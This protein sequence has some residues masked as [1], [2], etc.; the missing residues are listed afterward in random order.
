MSDLL[1]RILSAPQEPFA[2]IYRPERDRET[3]EAFRLV[4]GTA[5]TIADAVSGPRDRLIVL[6]YAQVK[7]RKFEAVDEG[8]P[9]HTMAIEDRE[10]VFLDRLLGRLPRGDVHASGTHF[11]LEDEAFAERVRNVIEDEIGQGAGSNFVL[12]RKLRTQITDFEPLHCLA[13]FR[14][15]LLK[16]T[17]AYWAFV[18]NTGEQVFL[19]VSPE[20]HASLRDGEVTMNPISGTY[21]YPPGGPTLPSVLDFLSDGK[22]IAEL[23]MVVDEELKVMSRLCEDG[24]TAI[25]PRLKALSRVAHTE[26]LLKGRTKAGVAEVLRETLLAPT[27]TGSPVQSAC[28]VLARREP[29]GRRYYSG[30]VGLI[31][32]DGSDVSLDSAIAIRTAEISPRGHVE[33]GVGATIV[34]DSVPLSEAQETRNKARSLLDAFSADR[35]GIDSWPEVRAAL[36]G[37]NRE[38]SQFWTREGQSRGS[39][40]HTLSDRSVL[41][42]DGRDTFTAM[43]ETLIRAAGANATVK[44]EWDEA[45]LA[46][47]DLVVAGPGPGDPLDLSDPRTVRLRSAMQFMLARDI[48]FLAVCLSHQI[49]LGLLDVPIVCLTPPNQGVQAKIELGGRHETVGFYNTFCGRLE[50][51]IENRLKLS[52]ITT[53]ADAA[54]R[55]IHA[56]AGPSFASVQFHLESVLTIDGPGILDRLVAPI[57]DVRQVIDQRA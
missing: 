21:A 48:P 11:N 53:S 8:L 4:P 43:I 1:T 40:T 25:G 42:L 20:L 16:E 36:V 3:V 47:S 51:R 18:I 52:G 15:L 9:I 37:R 56:I 34:R 17:S 19:G 50:D 49:L 7:E 2:L 33:I 31:E 35:F 14:A 41:I 57:L 23:F 27:V 46:R 45:D 12:H 38:I 39:D 24:G 55:R 54:T 22:E 44:T 26:Y 30:V 5:S 6:P 10:S 28:E 32:H 13:L 29:E